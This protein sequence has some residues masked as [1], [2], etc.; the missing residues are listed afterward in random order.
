VQEVQRREKE[1]DATVRK[2]AE[3][4]QYEVRT[5]ADATQYQLKTE[6]DGEAEAIR[7]RGHG[8]ADA[9]KA[10]GLA[11]AEVIREQGLSEAEATAKK[12]E[13]WKE[14]TQAAIIQQIIDALP[15]VASAVSAPLAQTDR[16]VV[17]NS[18]GSDGAG[19]GTS[20]VT[21]DVA[22]IVSQV[23][24]TIEALTGIDL[25]AALK[26]LPGLKEEDEAPEDGHH[27]E[28]ARLEAAEIEPSEPAAS[29]EPQD[30]EPA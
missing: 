1:L 2:P 25:V 18:G 11:Q 9:S 21:K 5:L 4:R 17:I 26:E 14:Y 16:I 3:A 23:P 24:T 29:E 22:D 19:A 6:A 20:K 7:Q 13:A 8:E 30:E 15:E 12:A 28:Q 10:R 27:A